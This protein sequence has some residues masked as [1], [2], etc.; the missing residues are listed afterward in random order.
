MLLPMGHLLLVACYEDISRLGDIDASFVCEGI[1]F[2]L[3]D[4]LDGGLWPE[5]VKELVAVDDE[6]VVDQSLSR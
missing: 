4:A 5:Q 6:A 3:Q 2:V 1:F